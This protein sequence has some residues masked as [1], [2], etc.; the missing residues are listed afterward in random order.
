MVDVLIQ[1]RICGVSQEIEAQWKVENVS[2]TVVTCLPEEAHKFREWLW[3]KWRG[4][5]K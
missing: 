4:E 5:K 1:G 2:E 3:L